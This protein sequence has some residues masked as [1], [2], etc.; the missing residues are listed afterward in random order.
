MRPKL[1]IGLICLIHFGRILVSAQ[2]TEAI[3]TNSLLGVTGLAVSVGDLS[4]GIESSGLSVALLRADAESK[5]KTAGIKIIPEAG[6]VDS[7]GGAEL[8]LEVNTLKYGTTQYSYCIQ[9]SV[10][11]KVQLFRDPTRATLGTTGSTT[12][13]GV[14]GETKVAAAIREQAGVQVD[15]FIV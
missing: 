9:M 15:Q 7:A 1:L 13:M 8:Y 5:L 12:V 2:I 14:V 4:P 3:S 11:Q 10:I 6:W